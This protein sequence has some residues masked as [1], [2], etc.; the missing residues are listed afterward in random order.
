MLI[1]RQ[2][3]QEHHYTNL[4][5]LLSAKTWQQTQTA[6]T[7]QLLYNLYFA[8]EQTL[9][10]S[11]YNYLLAY[12][13]AIYAKEGRRLSEARVLH[14]NGPIKP[15][16]P[17]HTLHAIQRDA[18]LIQAL[19]FWYDAYIECLKDL[20]LRSHGLHVQAGARAHEGV[21]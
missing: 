5:V 14:F 4:L 8:G 7:D 19:K 17:R 2:L 6:H 20:H 13:A 21:Q 9:V 18:A 12:R 3:L 15:W 10:N 11:A 1:D 16:Q